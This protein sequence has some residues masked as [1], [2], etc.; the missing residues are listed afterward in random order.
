MSRSPLRPPVV[1]V[2]GAS[3]AAAA[4]LTAHLWTAPAPQRWIVE[5]S[6]PQPSAA[7]DDVRPA[8]LVVGRDV[9]GGHDGRRGTL[10]GVADP[11][12]AAAANDLLTPATPARPATAGHATQDWVTTVSASTG[13]PVRALRSYADAAL[14]L[15]VEQPTCRVGWTTLAGV[16]AVESGHG[17][18]GGASVR[19]DGRAFPPVIGPALDGVGVAALKASPASTALHGD[20]VWEHAVGPMQFIPET[21][22]RWGSDGDGDGVADPQDLDDAAVA[23]GRYLCARGGD[24]SGAT[25]WHAA[26]LSYNRSDAYVAQVLAVADGYATASRPSAARPNG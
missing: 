17:T 19:P 16:G 18:H 1:V 6:E 7:R 11:V 22:S 13:I 14:A 9:A 3:V 15:A 20:T 4:A 2:V 12:S 24:L 23:A 21:W 10:D 8:A 5:A 25:D 26:V